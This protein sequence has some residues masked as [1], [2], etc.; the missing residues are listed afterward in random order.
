LA[1]GTNN[2]RF[3]ISAGEKTWIHNE[4]DLTKKSTAVGVGRKDLH[5]EKM[6][7]TGHCRTWIKLGNET[8]RTETR[9]PR[10]WEN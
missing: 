3:R 5:D 10:Y 9:L 8:S 1:P 7:K 4:S 2:S 6:P